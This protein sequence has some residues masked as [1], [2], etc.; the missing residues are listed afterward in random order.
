VLQ[1]T[2]DPYHNRYASDYVREQKIDQMC[3]TECPF[4][5][6]RLKDH[7]RVG[8]TPSSAPKHGAGLSSFLMKLNFGSP[9]KT[10]LTTGIYI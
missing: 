9:V 7:A 3:L 10:V 5:G 2:T 8:R 1:R 4:L 6:T